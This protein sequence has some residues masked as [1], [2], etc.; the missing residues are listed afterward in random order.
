[1]SAQVRNAIL[2][3]RRW[4][5]QKGLEESEV[6]FVTLDDLFDRCLSA[7]SHMPDRIILEGVAV[8]GSPRT[9]MLS[10]QSASGAD[11]A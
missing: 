8:D 9:V 11:N 1:M 6:S 2:V 10:F 5:E 4:D 3:Y 7:D